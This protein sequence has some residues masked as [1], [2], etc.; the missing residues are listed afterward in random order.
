MIRAYGDEVWGSMS[1]LASNFDAKNSRNEAERAFDC[2][3][4]ALV[5]Q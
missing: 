3:T 4:L 1:P 5:M 2:H